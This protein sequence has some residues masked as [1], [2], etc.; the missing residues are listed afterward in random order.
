M[1]PLRARML[2]DMSLAGL[3]VGTQKIYA[4]AVYRLTAHYRRSPDQLSEDEVR[5]YL[6]DLRERGVARGTFKTSRYGLQFFYRHTLGQDWGLF[7]GEKD[8]RAAAE[9]AA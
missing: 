1:S 9:A 5:R 7:G 8:R 3:A 6:L 4:Q 2:E